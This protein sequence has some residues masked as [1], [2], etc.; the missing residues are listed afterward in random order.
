MALQGEVFAV[1]GHRPEPAR[2]DR[3]AETARLGEVQ[4]I[5]RGYSIGRLTT[6]AH[7]QVFGVL[8]GALRTCRVLSD[9][10]RQIMAFLL[11]GDW[12][13]LEERLGHPTTVEAITEA[14]VVRLAQRQLAATG[15]EGSGTMQQILHA[16]LTAALDRNVTLGQ[17]SARDK[18]ASFLLDMSN[19][20]AQGGPELR[21]P[22][23]RYDIADYLGLR[24]E[25]VC[26]TLAQLAAAQVIAMPEPQHVR[27][28]DR[29]ALEAA[30]C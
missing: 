16:S 19:R 26:R 1:L 9:G 11:P 25:T 23:S 17:K 27:I 14:Q 21:L 12:C 22:M 24:S 6:G 4:H 8:A 20:L 29:A 18:L 10:R 7:E 5:R 28:L 2:R 3:P 15:T 30:L 13:W